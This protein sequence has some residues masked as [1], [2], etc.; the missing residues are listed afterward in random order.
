[1]SQSQQE[2]Y[3]VMF[4][5]TPQK[6]YQVFRM[7]SM[8]KQAAKSKEMKKQAEVVLQDDWEKFKQLREQLGLPES[9]DLKGKFIQLPRDKRKELIKDCEKKVLVQAGEK[10]YDFLMG[11]NKMLAQP[12]VLNQDVNFEQLKNMMT[13][14]GLQFHIKDLPDQTKELHFFAKDANVA[15]RAIDRTIDNIVNDPKSVTKPSLE[16]LIKQAKEQAHNQK[17]QKQEEKEVQLGETKSPVESA[18]DSK[19]TLESLSLFDEL[20]DGIEL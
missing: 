3:Q 7:L 20:K 16:N 1:M 19:E 14:Y 18:K 5:N 8:L 4:K 12:Q 11:T 15:A 10:D 6:L 2:A 13:E 17:Q 9:A